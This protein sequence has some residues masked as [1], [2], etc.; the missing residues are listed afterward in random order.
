VEGKQSSADEV[1]ASKF[2]EV[3]RKLLGRGVLTEASSALIRQVCF[4]NYI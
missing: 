2:P 3:S 4:G 1:A